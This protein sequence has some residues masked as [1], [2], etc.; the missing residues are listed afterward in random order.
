MWT[1]AAPS[2]ALLSLLVFGATSVAILLAYQLL[3][4]DRKQAKARMRELSAP[5][6]PRPR[7]GW[8]SA[9]AD[10]L[11]TVARPLVPG[12]EGQRG[13]LQQ[14]LI[15]AGFYEPNALT[16]FLG[17]K[18]VLIA[19]AVVVALPVGLA[20]MPPVKALATGVVLLGLGMVLPGLWLDARKASRQT[21]LRRALPDALDM[22]V[23]CVEGG[24][25]FNGAL[26]RVTAEMQTVHPVLGAELGIVQREIMLNLSP[27]EALQ[28]FGQRSDLE[29]VR[30][31]AAVIL[32]NERL[33]ASVVKALRVHSDAMRQQRQQRIEELAQKAAVK[34]LFPTL[35]CI[36][37][38][39]FIVVL[40]PAAFQIRAVFSRMK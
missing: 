5:A 31:L 7:L 32:Q 39:I 26:Q 11:P 30:G 15:A 33:G 29:E 16:T 22:L 17:V 12:D 4:R 38:A 6:T 21:A 23:L 27:A 28:K 34:I 36:F 24:V 37:P 13:Q 18:M 1:E 35:L 2:G 9:L 3:N 14:R 10:R 20:G 8:L 19:L 40:G 25:S